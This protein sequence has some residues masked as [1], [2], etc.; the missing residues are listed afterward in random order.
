MSSMRL[1]AVAVLVACGATDE[2]GAEVVSVLLFENGEPLGGVPIVFS[3]ASGATLRRTTTDFDGVAEGPLGGSVGMVSVEHDDTVTTVYDVEPGALLSYDIPGEPGSV[4]LVVKGD[5]PA[6]T[7]FTVDFGCGNPVYVTPSTGL[8]FGAEACVADEPV[9]LL[10][11]A[12]DG[13]GVMVA[14]ATAVDLESVDFGGTVLLP[15]FRRDF[16]FVNVSWRGAAPGART[17]VRARTS[18][19]GRWYEGA[20]RVLDTESGAVALPVGAEGFAEAFEVVVARPHSE[21]DSQLVTVRST[22]E[23]RRASVDLGGPEPL[24]TVALLVEEGEMVF[25][26]PSPPDDHVASLVELWLD[27]KRWVAVAPPGATEL[28]VP[29]HLG[30]LRDGVRP[31]VTLVASP[32]VTAEHYARRAA[33]GS[34]P[35]TFAPNAVP[36]VWR[37]WVVNDPALS[38]RL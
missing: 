27:T 8:T 28:A 35:R 30:G 6:G 3:D 4:P 12:L 29:E 1:L 31:L 24:V 14:V 9:S 18:R 20:T 19:N 26:A 37:S 11:K 2:P 5:P 15:P 17:D 22:S 16:E 21:G 23:E 38:S 13:D 36:L 32:D 34:A 7:K 25:S 33:I 10:A